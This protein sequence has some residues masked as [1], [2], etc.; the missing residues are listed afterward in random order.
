[1]Y[2]TPAVSKTISSYYLTCQGTGAPRGE[3]TYHSDL[4]LPSLHSC[5]HILSHLCSPQKM[6]E[7]TVDPEHNFWRAGSRQLPKVLAVQSSLL[8]SLEVKQVPGQGQLQQ[9]KSWGGQRAQGVAEA[10]LSDRNLNYVVTQA[11]GSLGPSFSIRSEAELG[12]V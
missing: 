2:L 1:M 7:I 12:E 10:R 5:S 3:V 6:V 8:R 11:L 9:S 4:R